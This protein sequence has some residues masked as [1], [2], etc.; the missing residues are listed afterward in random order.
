M[1]RRIVFGAA[2]AVGAVLVG[3]TSVGGKASQPRPFWTGLAHRTVSA[4]IVSHD[5]RHDTS[6]PLRE[7][8]PLQPGTREEAPDNPMRQYGYQPGGQR[9]DPAVQSTKPLT[10]MPGLQQS[11]DAQTQTCGCLPPDTNGD[12]S[13]N[14][15]VQ[16]VN[17]TFAVYSKTGSVLYGPAATNTLFSGFGGDC[18]TTNNGDPIV[19]YD[20]LADRWVI[21]QFDLNPPYSQCVAVSTTND[22]TGSYHR[23]QFVLDQ[24]LFNDYP[25][26]GVWPDAYYMS[27]NDFYDG[28]PF[29][30]VTVAA[31]DRAAMIAGTSA[32]MVKF[33]LGTSFGGMLPSDLDGTTVPPSGSPDYFAQFDDDANGYPQDQLEIWKFHVDFATP[34]NST[35]TSD[36]TLATAAFDSNLADIPQK[37]TSQPLEA[38]S[39]RL[40]YRLA[41]RNFGDHEAMVVNHSVDSNGSGLGGPRWYELRRTGGNWSIFQQSTYAPDTENRWMGSIAM[42]KKGDIATGFSFANSSTYASIGY[43]GRLVTDPVNTLTQESTFFSGSGAQTGTAGRWGDYSSITVDPTDDCTFWYTTEYL[44]TTGS[45]PWRTRIGSFSFP[46]CST[47]LQPPAI[48]SFAPSSGPPA[49]PVSITGSGFTGTSA[50]KFNGTSAAYTVNSD[51]SLSTTVPNG[52]TTGKITVTNSLGTATSTSNFVVVTAQPPQVTGF[53]PQSG[54][55]GTTVSVLGKNFT[56][57]TSVK[58]GTVSATFTVV[59]STKITT[60]VPQITRGSYRWQVTTSAGTGTSFQFFRV[61]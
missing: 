45:A 56:G 34:A 43:A 37:G 25:K 61:F 39:D 1:N 47:P 40:M 41:Y 3:V 44:Q 19:Q 50:V 58:L 29:V 57:A 46:S 51:T 23:Y 15:Y 2:L 13:T 38:L 59:S 9:F 22:A 48:T 12:V 10:P 5:V 18:E 16:T 21:T 17:L 11:F 31:L 52:A 36:S 8:T 26:L 60:K 28:G 53:T 7:I 4:P 55:V 32:A 14:Q 6:K 20:P 42:D 24:H 35:F 54:R 30:G 49:T 33:D 27:F